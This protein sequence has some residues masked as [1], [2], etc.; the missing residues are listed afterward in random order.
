MELLSLIGNSVDWT[1]LF[2]ISAIGLGAIIL[3][4]VA[5]YLLVS[6]LSV[7]LKWV[8]RIMLVIIPVLIVIYL[9]T[10][11]DIILAKICELGGICL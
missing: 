9:F 8:A 7:L 6:A 3:I 5:V 2:T 10:K 1:S 4:C 11:S